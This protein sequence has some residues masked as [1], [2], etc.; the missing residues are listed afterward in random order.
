M[1]II[2]GEE[3]IYATLFLSFFF[4]WRI[5]SFL[6]RFGN[7]S[8]SLLNNTVIVHFFFSKEFP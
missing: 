5:S 1:A 3:M 4:M 7:T 6:L 2:A 8:L